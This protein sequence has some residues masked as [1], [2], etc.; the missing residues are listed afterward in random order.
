MDPSF[1]K[2]QE[3]IFTKQTEGMDK[4][5]KVLKGIIQG[6]LNKYLSSIC[7]LSQGFVKEEKVSVEKIL[8]S[9]SKE[10][11]GKVEIVDYV[12]FKLGEELE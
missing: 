3:E 9:L 11:G 2:E 7:L 4:P 8:A 12:S 5:E 1:L 6:K 10:V